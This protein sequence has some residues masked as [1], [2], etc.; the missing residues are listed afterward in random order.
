MNSAVIH[1]PRA[2]RDG[3]TEP[4]PLNTTR[5][6]TDEDEDDSDDDDM[7]GLENAEGEGGDAGSAPTWHHV[8]GFLA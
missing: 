8:L 3:H 6:S 4:C 7:P 5:L 2:A 1:L